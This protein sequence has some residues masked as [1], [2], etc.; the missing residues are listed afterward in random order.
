M[1]LKYDCSGSY[2]LPVAMGLTVYVSVM[3]NQHDFR[4]LSDGI[5]DGIV[6]KG[7]IYQTSSS[8]VTQKSVEYIEI[9]ES[10]ISNINFEDIT[11]ATVTIQLAG[12]LCNRTL[13]NA[14]INLKRDLCP[15]FV[16]PLLLEQNPS[17]PL[18]YQANYAI[19]AH[20]MTVEFGRLQTSNVN[21]NLEVGRYLTATHNNSAVIDLRNVTA[22]TTEIQET[23][24]FEYH[25]APTIRVVLSGVA[26]ATCDDPLATPPLVAPRLTATNVTVTVSEQY[27]GVAECTNVPGEVLFT[28]LLG[29]E[30][31]STELLT[32]CRPPMACTLT[33]ETDTVENPADGTSMQV[34]AH[35]IQL[36]QIG[37][38]VLFEPF[39]KSLFV[40]M[41]ARGHLDVVV[42]SEKICICTSALYLS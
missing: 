10:S 25:P 3:Y 5:V 29:D 18:S 37:D 2:M 9:G 16:F 4:R 24:R 36:L 32:A 7:T 40:R 38:P 6:L 42:V 8:G 27:P 31:G 23:V 19:P 22:N 41:A 14:I 35:A 39:T 13:G 12:G 20:Q 30:F 33:L 1:C 17:V 26:P 34:N 15:N 11:T 21:F 28:S